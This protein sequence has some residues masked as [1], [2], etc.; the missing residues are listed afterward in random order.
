L[1]DQ[2]SRLN[3]SE[4][5]LI[6]NVSGAIRILGHKFK[7][8][9][10]DFPNTIIFIDYSSFPSPLK[11]WVNNVAIRNSLDPVTLGNVLY[12]ALRITNVLDQQKGI[13]IENLSI[14]IAETTDQ[15]G[16]AIS[17][18]QAAFA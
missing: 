9:Y 4:D 16:K 5:L 1:A 2:A 14:K 15:I 13:I 18:K 6:E 10:S 8:N 17:D 11:R 12:D 7:H 3:I